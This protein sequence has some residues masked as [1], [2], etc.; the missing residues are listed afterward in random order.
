MREDVV[1]R[2]LVRFVT[3]AASGAMHLFLL[4]VFVLVSEATESFWL[5]NNDFHLFQPLYQFRVLVRLNNSVAHSFQVR[6]PSSTH[7]PQT[8]KLEQKVKA[9]HHRRSDQPTQNR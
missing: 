3:S 2:G 9:Q 6:K 1:I 8:E 4:F 7:G 5:F